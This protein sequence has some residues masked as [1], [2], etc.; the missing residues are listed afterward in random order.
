MTIGKT[1]AYS[2]TYSRCGNAQC[3]MV[4]GSV[5]YRRVV[6]VKQTM[7]IFFYLVSCFRFLFLIYWPTFKEMYWTNP[8]YTFII[9]EADL[10]NDEC[11]WIIIGLMQKNTR[12]KRIELKVETVFEKMTYKE[13]IN[14]LFYHLK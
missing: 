8:Q 7:V 10:I 1:V 4:N 14:N 9:N 12:Q 2:V 5:A 11:C 13:T 6:V 3:F